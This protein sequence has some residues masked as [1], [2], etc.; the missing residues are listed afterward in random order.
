[1][2][3]GA[4]DTPGRFWG[5]PARSHGTVSA[6][7]PFLAKF[8]MGGLI[9]VTIFPGFRFNREGYLFQ[10]GGIRLHLLNGGNAF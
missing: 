8:A 5:Y 4:A 6:T 7:K 2:G 10:S 1:V 9:P 3:I